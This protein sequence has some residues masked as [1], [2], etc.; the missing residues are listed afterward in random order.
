MG[1]ATHPGREIREYLVG[2]ERYR[3]PDDVG[4]HCVHE[5]AGH[6]VQ[7]D[8]VSLGRVGIPCDPRRAGCLAA[9]ASRPSA[10]QAKPSTLHVPAWLGNPPTPTPHH[11]T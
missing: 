10:R 3:R 9:L 7:N 1:L 11:T 5:V 8:G 4:E 6:V 2:R